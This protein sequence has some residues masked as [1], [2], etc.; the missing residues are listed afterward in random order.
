MKICKRAAVFVL[1]LALLLSSIDFIQIVNAAAEEDSLK[2]ANQFISYIVDKKT[3]RFGI[4]TVEGAPRRE[5]DRMAP[6]LYKGEKPDTSFTTFRIDGED[7]IFGN[8]YG[9]LGIQGGMGKSPATQGGVN[10]SV[11]KLGD[12]EIRQQLTLIAD[13]SNPDVGNV[14]VTYTV[15]NNGKMGKSIGSRILFDTMLGTN[16]GSPLIIPGIEKPVEYEIS[17]DGDQV[18][19]FWQSA[20]TDISPEVVSYGLVSGWNNEAPDRMTAAH[21]SGI[22]QPSGI[23]RR[24]VQSNLL[25]YSTSTIKAT[26]RL[27]CI[28]TRKPLNRERQEYMK[29]SMV[30]DCL[31][32]QTAT[33][34]LQR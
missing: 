11:W 9:F 16:D 4:S 29:P 6:L 14:K 13:S 19:S 20:D 3:G 28:G 18:P 12:V 15:V 30:W 2:V 31:C 26:V 22:A 23:I 1:I 21:W 33:P 5:G 8:D 34:S 25:R 10:I 27:H 24:T 7:Y 17:F 32:P